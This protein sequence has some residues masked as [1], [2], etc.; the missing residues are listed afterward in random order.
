MT[1]KDKIEDILDLIDIDLS[2]YEEG[3][4]IGFHFMV[5]VDHYGM[6]VPMDW[7]ASFPEYK[8]AWGKFMEGQTYI[9]GG[10]FYRDVTRFLTSKLRYLESK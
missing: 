2:D 1:M 3:H 9:E 10:F 8:Q 7:I 5:Y 4:R 6:L